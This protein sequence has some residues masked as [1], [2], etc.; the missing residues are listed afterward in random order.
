MV[1]CSR[2]SAV[3]TGNTGNQTAKSSTKRED[4]IRKWFVIPFIVTAK[5]ETLRAYS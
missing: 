2:R 1:G 5:W 4:V 3:E